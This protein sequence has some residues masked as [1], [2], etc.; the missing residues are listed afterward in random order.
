MYQIYSLH[1][2]DKMLYVGYTKDMQKR[3]SRH[4]SK[5]NPVRL[6][7]EYMDT[8]GRNRSDY[9]MELLETVPSTDL[10]IVEAVEHS[11]VDMFSP[12]CNANK[13]GGSG[14]DKGDP[15]HPM[16]R[17]EVAAKVAAAKTGENNPMK[18][19][20]VAAKVSAARKGVPKPWMQGENHH[21]ARKDVWDQSEKICELYKVQL[22]SPSEIAKMLNTSKGTINRIL[23][24][25]GVPIR[26]LSEA[27]KI[28]QAK[29]NKTD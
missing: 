13:T 29:R 18:R 28:R 9:R 1:H 11:Y 25:C 24:H 27:Q 8:H 26:S 19:P 20:E 12:P 4:I 23:L 17:P 22:M 16:K 21:Q 10:G 2:K 15:N 3:F 5:S 6:V 14:L 7:R